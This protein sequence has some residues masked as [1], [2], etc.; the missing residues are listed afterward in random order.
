MLGKFAV[1]AV[2]RPSARA[3]RR[4]QRRRRL[5]ARDDRVAA[6]QL[7]RVARQ[8]AVDAVG[9]EADRRQRRHRERH[10]D[11]QQAQLAGAKVAQRAG[12]SRAATRKACA[13]AAAWCRARR[14][15]QRRRRSSAR[16]LPE[17]RTL[18]ASGLNRRPRA[19]GDPMP[20]GHAPSF[21]LRLARLA[22]DRPRAGRRRCLHAAA[23]P[24]DRRR[25]R[26]AEGDRH[27]LGAHRCARSGRPRRAAPRGDLRLRRLR[28]EAAH[29]ALRRRRRPGARG[30]TACSFS[31]AAGI[32][33]QR[34]D[35]GGL[36]HG[37]WTALRFIYPDADIPIVPL[38]FVPDDPPAAQFALGAALQPLRA[39]GVLVLGSGSITHNLRRLFVNGLR[40]RSRPA[41]ARRQRGVPPLDRRARQGARLGR[42][43]RLSQPGAARGRHAP[44]RRA[45]AAV[46]RRSRRRRA[47]RRAAAHP[48]QRDDGQP[49]H[50]RL[51]VRP[52]RRRARGRRSRA[53]RPQPA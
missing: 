44:D 25:L 14:G 7:A 43:L 17:S 31:Q 13:A 41:R 29:A 2:A 39:E 23:R 20:H 30:A 45:P 35:Q 40:P 52:A 32:D 12:A 10:R 46:V 53:A 9:E 38:A 50:G 49:R 19:G 36:D 28:S 1:V 5:V 26:P 47:R 42:A 48:R 24:G 34:V 15:A 33:A 22:D 27:R 18:R 37:A 11:D 51:R 16:N 4:E 21:A 3:S 8:A 6:E